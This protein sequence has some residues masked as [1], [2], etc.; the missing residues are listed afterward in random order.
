MA[1]ISTSSETVPALSAMDAP[2]LLI[3]PPWGLTISLSVIVMPPPKSVTA[4]RGPF[5][6]MLAWSMT[7]FVPF[8]PF[9]PAIPQL[10]LSLSAPFQA[11]APISDS[12]VLT[13]TAE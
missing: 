6:A 1:L 5:A 9:G 10:P 8:A 13:V 7:S 12:S 3:L 2:S 4:P 11:D